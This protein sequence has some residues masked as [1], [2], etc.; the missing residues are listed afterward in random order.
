MKPTEPQQTAKT[1]LGDKLLDKLRGE[2]PQTFT[3]E[4]LKRLHGAFEDITQ[5]NLQCRRALYGIAEALK[6]HNLQVTDTTNP[7]GTMGFDLEN[8]APPD[9]APMS[10]N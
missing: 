6:R 1:S 10:V 8:A 2:G 3:G 7:D 9:D 5:E 4:E